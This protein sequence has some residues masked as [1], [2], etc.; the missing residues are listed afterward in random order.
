MSGSFQRARSA[1]QRELRRSAILA[2]AR[3]LLDERRVADV[4]LNE[5]ARRAGLAKSNVLRYFESRE[6]VLLEIYDQE[7][8]AWLDALE[9]AMGAVETDDIEAIAGALARTVAARPLLC[10]LSASAPGVLEHNLSAAVAVAYKLAASAHAVRLGRIVAS[11]IELT[12]AARLGLAAAANLGIGGT[13]A[14]T[15]PSAGMAA[16]Y[17]L[18]PALRIYRF[19]FEPSLREYF[20]TVLTGLRQREPRVGVDADGLD[21]IARA[22]G[23]AGDG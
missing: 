1:E 18:H 8:G 21:E 2:A 4:S 11:R 16:A 9:P 5:L 17:D 15:R 22:I 10:E 12:P 6:A 3:E 23:A 20:A 13:W 7:F 14:A 19:G